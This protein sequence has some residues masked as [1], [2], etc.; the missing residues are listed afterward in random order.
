MLLKEHLFE[1][2][3]PLRRDDDL[4]HSAIGDARYHVRFAETAEELDAVLKLRFDVFNLELGEGLTSS[5]LTGRDEDEFDASCH[6]LMVVERSSGAVVGTYRLQTSAM[7]A[8]G[9]GFYSSGEFDLS[10]L[11]ASVLDDAV[12]V[13]RACI[14]RVHRNTRVLFLLWRGLAAYLAHNRKRYLFGCCS[15]T[16]QDAREGGR[17]AAFL[18]RGG[19]MHPTLRVR[20][21]PGLECDPAE[22]DEDGGAGTRVTP[23]FNIY[24]RYGARVCGLPA[25]DRSFG[26]IDFLVLFDADGMDRRTHRMFFEG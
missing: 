9:R 10:C 22:A 17:V 4:P 2:S 19:H 23:L 18:E 11:P 21:R 6:H 14:A 1:N 15:L 5:F 25:I 24:L 20:P 13:G 16:S 26:T 8:A 12:E 3:A 7:A